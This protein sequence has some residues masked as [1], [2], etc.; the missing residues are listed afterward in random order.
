MQNST[1]KSDAIT[2]TRIKSLHP[3]IQDEV[4]ELVNIANS[5]LSANVQMRIVQGFRTFDEQNALFL[6]RPKVTNAKGGQSIHNYGLAIDFCLLINNNEIS[7]DDT[8]DLDHDNIADW[9]EVVTVFA[10]KGWTWG[11]NWKT[12]KDKPHLEKT[13]GNT[14]QSLLKKYNDKKFI[15][16]T[17]YVQI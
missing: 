2:L 8:K 6:K 5:K 9:L 7:W 14:W 4:R 11:G 15:E 16:G 13:F 17:Q 3:K 1:T 12:F 10:R